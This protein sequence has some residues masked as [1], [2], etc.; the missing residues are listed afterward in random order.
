MKYVLFSLLSMVILLACET[1]D[2]PENKMDLDL[3][4]AA[5]GFNESESDQ[6]AIII[7]D[8]VMTAMGGRNN[9]DKERFFRWNFFGRRTLWWDKL[10]GKVA[11]QMHDADSMK[12][13]LNI[14]DD[15]GRYSIRGEEITQP[16]SVRKF[17]QKGKSMWINDSYWLFMPFKLKDSGVT[18]T[19]SSQDTLED[20]TV[21]DVLQLTFKD[22]GNTPQ[23]KYHVWVDRTDNLI[24]QWAFYRKYDMEEPNFI[25]P[26]VNYKKYNTLLLSGDRGK[27]QITDI[28]VADQLDDSIFSEL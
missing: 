27:R 16:D 23:N 15:S 24:K 7:A 22:I 2:K 20:N 3:N 6:K 10:E 12:I 13:V 17:V 26:W 25:N 14:F 18:L 19:Y 4:P 11:I 5:D 8:K 1:K 28:L 21:C 9:W